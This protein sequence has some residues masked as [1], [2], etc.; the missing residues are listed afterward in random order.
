MSEIQGGC[1]SLICTAGHD[2]AG[3]NVA[4]WDTLAP[5]KRANVQSFSFH[6]SGASALLFAPQ[7]LQLLSAGKR[8]QVAVWDLRQQRQVHFFRAHDQV[9]RLS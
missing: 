8:G 3:K 4:L 1:S 6:E 2:A 5:Q 7:H 9:G